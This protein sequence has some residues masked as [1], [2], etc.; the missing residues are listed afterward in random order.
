MIPIARLL[1]F[2][3]LLTPFGAAKHQQSP[4]VDNPAPNFNVITL[5]ASLQPVIKFGTLNNDERLEL[6]G[7][8]DA[9]VLESGRLAIAPS[10]S[11][12]SMIATEIRIVEKPGTFVNR[13][14]RAGDGPGEYRAVS[15][16]V[17]LG[18]DSLLVVDQTQGRVTLLAPSGAVVKSTPFEGTAL[19]CFA[20]GSFLVKP[21]APVQI[22]ALRDP[23]RPLVSY[24]IQSLS[25]GAAP[26]KILELS[27]G[28]PSLQLPSARG[29]YA[30]P[31]LPFGRTAYVRVTANTI[32]YGIGDMYEYQVYSRDGK[33]LRTVR[34]S[35]RPIPI[36][37]ESLAAAR[38]GLER[39]AATP[40]GKREL[41]R[42]TFPTTFPA[43]GKIE[44]EEDGTVWIA[45]RHSQIVWARFDPSGKLSGTFQT[46]KETYVVRFSRGHVLLA[47]QNRADGV[48]TIHMHRI[49]PVP[50]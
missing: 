32:V 37:A 44:V 15:Q 43:Y 27:A 11:S 24:S 28:D 48:S 31:P 21:R 39:V 17:G 13:F 29:G 25:A 14:G 35:V 10:R 12:Q 46:P 23:K 34:A 18:K 7:I 36:P 22:R 2:A 26:R 42:T 5:R 49:E 41:D 9:V 4:I 40:E 45:S 16:M 30:I 33:L 50:R 20:D 19:C 6:L 47:S 1:C 38:T 3:T 8:G